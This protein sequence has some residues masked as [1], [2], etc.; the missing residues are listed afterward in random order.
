MTPTQDLLQYLEEL[1][2]GSTLNAKHICTIMYHLER[3]GH[4]EAKAFS[5]HP[6]SQSGKFQNKLDKAFNFNKSDESLYPIELPCRS[7]RTGERKVSTV[8]A[9]PLHESLANEITENP[10]ILDGWRSLITEK[11]WIASYENHWKVKSCKSAKEKASVLPIVLYMDGAQFTKTDSIYVFTGRFGFSRVRHLLWSVRKSNACDCGCKGWCTFSQLFLWIAW[12]LFCLSNGTYP[13]QRHDNSD[14]DSKRAEYAGQ[15]LGF[16]AIVVD[17]CGDWKEFANGW[18]F[19]S[20]SAKLPCFICD[21]KKSDLTNPK[22]ISTDRQEHEYDDACKASEIIVPISVMAQLKEI[23]FK[24]ETDNKKKGLTLRAD[25]ISTTLKLKSGDRLEPSAA[26]PDIFKVFVLDSKNLPLVLKFW[27]EKDPKIVMHRNPV[28]CKELG[29][30]YRT[31]SIDVL[32]CLHL[33]VYLAFITKVIHLLL[34]VDAFETRETRQE[35][36]LKVSANALTALLHHWYKDYKK[37]LEP[38]ARKGFTGVNYLTDKMLGKADMSKLVKLKAAESRHFMEFALFLVRHYE[39]ILRPS[40]EYENLLVAG[41]T[42]HD[43]MYVVNHNPRK[44]APDVVDT[45]CKLQSR[46]NH[47]AWAAGVKMLPKHHQARSL[48]LWNLVG[49]NI[50]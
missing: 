27:R 21:I 13:S 23:C 20:W 25:V 36:H 41:E 16:F 38:Q 9:K 46:H 6:L 47:A 8:A 1:Y 44:L 28:I 4:A 37:Q 50:I 34:I 43:W 15:A 3:M 48:L 12:T 40:C 26:M 19:P 14:L 7:T 33:G 45:L 49:V 5:L 29:I 30:G 35:D 22:A 18:G 10:K 32:H 42:L 31:F 17:I 11:E 2:F 39:S 24:L